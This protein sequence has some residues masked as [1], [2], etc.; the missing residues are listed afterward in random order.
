MS[1]FIAYILGVLT[2]FMI[3]IPFW[4]ISTKNTSV[5]KIYKSSVCW[6]IC[7]DTDEPKS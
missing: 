4:Y 3:L 1:P 6:N 7:P 2:V 5:S